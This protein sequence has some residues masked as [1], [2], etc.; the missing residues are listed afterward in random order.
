[1]APRGIPMSSRHPPHTRRL[2]KTSIDAATQRHWHEEDDTLN[3]NT[4]ETET[5]AYY[6]CNLKAGYY[7]L[8]GVDLAHHTYA[9]AEK[10]GVAH[11]MPCFGSFALG[12]GDR[13]HT[14]VRYEADLWSPSLIWSR[15]QGKSLPANLS[16]ALGMAQFTLT[17]YLGWTVDEWNRHWGGSPEYGLASWSGLLYGVTGVCHQACNRILFSTLQGGF[18][19]SPVNWPPSLSASYWVYGFYGKDY[20]SAMILAAALVAKAVAGEKADQSELFRAHE[21]AHNLRRHHIEGVIND[22]TNGGARAHEVRGLLAYLPDELKISDPAAIEEII[23]L[24]RRFSTQKSDMDRL[25]IKTSTPSNH[26]EYAGKVNDDFR[27]MLNGF[28]NTMPPETFARLFP[29]AGENRNYTL[30]NRGM[31]PANYLRHREGHHT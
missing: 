24:D 7:N 28:R 17:P 15:N 3:Q 26:D 23:N 2:R 18:L 11:V 4:E 10:N 5:A 21:L 27:T 16:V 30:I 29:D 13:G 9:V 22:Q 8:A 14:G 12:E 19:Y 20:G 1:M 6:D 31:M 25:L